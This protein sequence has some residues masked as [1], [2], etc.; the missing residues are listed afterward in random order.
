MVDVSNASAK[1]L[2]LVLLAVDDL[3]ISS[4]LIPYFYFFIFF[5]D[6]GS[7]GCRDG[8]AMLGQIFFPFFPSLVLMKVIFWGVFLNCFI[9]PL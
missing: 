7:Y 5:G 1:Y 2:L 8:I 6:R 3:L 4:A 9:F